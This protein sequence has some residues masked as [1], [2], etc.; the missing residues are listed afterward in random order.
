MNEQPDQNPFPPLS[1]QGAAAVNEFLEELYRR[2]QSHYFA[3]LHRHY[4]RRAYEENA[5][6]SPTSSLD[7]PP[8]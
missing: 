8:F 6:G 2:F 4:R 1:D 7:D 5:A 3:Q